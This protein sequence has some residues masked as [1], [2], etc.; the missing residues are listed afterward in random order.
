MGAPCTL[1]ASCVTSA[2]AQPLRAS[3]VVSLLHEAGGSSA[4]SDDAASADERS[5]A[6]GH[7]RR[8][9][10]HGNWSAA[11]LRHVTHPTWNT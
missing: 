3:C 7:G 4:A 10:R 9:T 2:G 1:E 5:D 11:R 6:T 8:S